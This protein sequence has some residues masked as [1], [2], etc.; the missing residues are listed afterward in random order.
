MEKEGRR[1]GGEGRWEQLERLGSKRGRDPLPTHGDAPVEMPFFFFFFYNC[2]QAH[3]YILLSSYRC[4]SVLLRPV[5]LGPLG[6][7]TTVLYG[8]IMIICNIEA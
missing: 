6:T 7:F 1:A 4:R 3:L 5:Q 8:Q 2:C